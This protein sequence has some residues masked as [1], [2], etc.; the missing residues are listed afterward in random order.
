MAGHIVVFGM[1]LRARSSSGMARE[2]TA[3]TNFN[4][5]LMCSGSW[6]PN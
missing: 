2:R 6:H 1:G 5:L 4:N 3:E